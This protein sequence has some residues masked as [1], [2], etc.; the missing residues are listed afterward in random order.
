MQNFNFV[1][2]LR[3]HEPAARVKQ[4]S[5]KPT[6]IQTSRQGWTA[7]LGWFEESDIE[8]YEHYSSS[9]ECE[10]LIAWEDLPL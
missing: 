8:G 5:S 10:T 4:L 2:I 1:V 7:V 3:Q 9:L 6:I